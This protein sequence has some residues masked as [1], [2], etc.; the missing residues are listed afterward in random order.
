MAFDVKAVKIPN[1]SKKEDW[2]NSITHMVGVPFGIAVLICC[3]IKAVTLGSAISI[4]SSAIY[5]LSVI[6]LY[7]C[8]SIYHALDKNL[9]KQVMRV[10]DHSTVFI[11]ISGTATPFALIT[12]RTANPGLGWTMFGIMWGVTA[13]AILF[14]FMN[15]EKFKAL[16]MVLY[17]ALGWTSVLGFKAAIS[18]GQN[19]KLAVVYLLAGG[20]SYTLGCI[21]YGLGKNHRYFHA[22]FHLFVLCGTALHFVAVYSYILA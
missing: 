3:V 15:Q 1:Y 16:Q 6:V 4:V 11:L 13:I 7:S 22:I 5:G 14:T 18:S 10:V 17:L 19:G 20:I 2:V 9:G 12:I 8:S 21:L